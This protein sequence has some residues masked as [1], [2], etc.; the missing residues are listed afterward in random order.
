MRRIIFVLFAA[1]MF[2]LLVS[3]CEQG[4]NTMSY[5]P[6]AET[7][8]LTSNSLVKVG[9][10]MVWADCNVYE[11]VV[12]PA[13]FKAK[14]G[15]FDQ[16]YAGGSFKD[17]IGLISESKPGDHDYNGGRWQLNLLKPGVSADK[18][19]WA[20]TVEDLDLNDFEAQEVYFECPLLPRKK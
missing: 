11:S 17:D 3:A 9:R 12:T 19:A 4:D 1:V 6:Q 8:N 5:M 14:S 16:L 18:Y 13:T 10:T 20:C 15:S 7:D 2:V